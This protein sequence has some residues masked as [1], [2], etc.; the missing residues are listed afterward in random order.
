MPWATIEPTRHQREPARA[1]SITPSKGLIPPTIFPVTSMT[2]ASGITISLGKGIQ[3]LSRA[4]ASTMPTRL[5]CI[6]TLVTTFVRDVVISARYT[7]ASFKRLRESTDV[8]AV[9]SHVETCIRFSD[10]ARHRPC[11]AA[12]AKKLSWNDVRLLLFLLYPMHMNCR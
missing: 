8:R 4:I 5:V 6:Y 2:P 11:Q 1:T 10:A 7:L 12:R 9:P 3:Q